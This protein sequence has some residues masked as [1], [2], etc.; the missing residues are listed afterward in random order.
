MEQCA[1]HGLRPVQVE[2]DHACLLVAEP[3][4]LD[5]V[6][7][8]QGSLDQPCGV[9]GYHRQVHG[10]LPSLMLVLLSKPVGGNEHLLGRGDQPRPV[11]FLGRA[12]DLACHR[13]LHV[14]EGDHRSA[15]RPRRHGGLLSSPEQYSPIGAADK[16]LDCICC[17]F[18]IPAVFGGTNAAQ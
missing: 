6:E 4:L 11:H 17:N 10:M 2:A 5:P 9:G 8:M 1:L 18:E 12:A 16:F 7:T 3:W 14:G 13:L 15:E